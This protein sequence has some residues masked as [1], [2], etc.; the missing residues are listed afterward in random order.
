[1]VKYSMTRPVL[2]AI[3]LL[4]VLLAPCSAHAQI[5]VNG[6]ATPTARALTHWFGQHVPAR[7]T[8]KDRFTVFPVSD[9]GMNAYLRAEDPD[10]DQNSQ[11]EDGTID[12]IFENDPPRITLRVSDP[13][14]PD[15]ATFAHEYGHYVWCRLFSGSDRKHYQA[16]Y[17]TQKAAHHLVSEYAETDSEEGFAEAF[18]FFLVDP[19][20]LERL[21]PASSRFLSRWSAPR[22]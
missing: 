22:S 11:D 19:A 13:A 1:M 14:A 21:D 12:G 3:L 6:P 18:S 2:P 8:P 17:R 9:S 4:T 15:Y 10:G 16:L 20:R 5:V 7:F